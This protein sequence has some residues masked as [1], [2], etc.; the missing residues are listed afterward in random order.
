MFIPSLKFLIWNDFFDVEAEGG[1]FD[2]KD[3]V[4]SSISFSTLTTFLIFTILD[5][6]LSISQGNYK[7]LKHFKNNT[8]S[9]SGIQLL[10]NSSSSSPGSPGKYENY[11]LIILLNMSSYLDTFRKKLNNSFRAMFVFNRVQILFIKVCS[12]L[13][14]NDIN[15]MLSYFYC[16]FWLFAL[17]SHFFKN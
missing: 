17:L 7:I 5:P 12:P 1:L 10:L 4:S 3:K 16:Y 2:F 15:N 11:I 14:K 13:M 8:D 9:S 6:H